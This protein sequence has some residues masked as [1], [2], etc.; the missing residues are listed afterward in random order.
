MKKLLIFAFAGLGI[1]ISF[2]SCEKED[3]NPEY[4]FTIQVKTFDDSV[5]VINSLVEV[6]A[7]VRG[8]T[9]YFVGYTNE[10]GKVSFKYNR[11]AIFLVRAFRGP[12][13][14]PSYIGCTEVR[15]EANTEVTKT[16]YV[17]KVDPEIPGC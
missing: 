9:P 12:I 7:P 17:K 3:L 5:R 1:I 8:S 15:L 11:D 6:I 14:D 4:P 16:V 2:G 13:Q 10:S